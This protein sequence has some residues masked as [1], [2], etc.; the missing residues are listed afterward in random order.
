L[1]A[2]RIAELVDGKLCD[3]GEV[4]I[5][6]GRRLLETLRQIRAPGRA[7]VGN[8]NVRPVR[9]ELA[10]G[11][12]YFGRHRSGVIRDGV[13]RSITPIGE[14]A[15]GVSV[16]ISAFDPKPSFRSGW[17]LALRDPKRPLILDAA[18]FGGCRLVRS[19]RGVKPL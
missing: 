17:P 11:V 18:R 3:A 14:A 2:V 4:R 16:R 8:G 7:A 12:K 1:E 5:G 13:I 9:P 10:L 19:K 15:G 6:L